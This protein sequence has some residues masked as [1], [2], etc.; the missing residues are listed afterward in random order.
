[1]RCVRIISVTGDELTEHPNV[2]IG[3]E[4]IVFAI[5]FPQGHPQLVVQLDKDEERGTQW[6]V[7]MFEIVD[8]RIP[9]N[10]AVTIDPEDGLIVGPSSWLRRG[11]WDDFHSSGPARRAER[12][13]AHEDYRRERA[14]VLGES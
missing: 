9:P 7:E 11:F 14:I 1:V 3:K 5:H 6:P 10:W 13:Q 2:T 12:R 8:N 4:Y